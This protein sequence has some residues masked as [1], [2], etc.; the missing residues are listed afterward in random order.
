MNRLFYLI[1]SIILISETLYALPNP[2]TKQVII[3]DTINREK[4]KY[5]PGAIIVKFKENS[6]FL[7]ADKKAKI[8]LMK[9]SFESSVV[10]VETPFKSMIKPNDDSYGISRITEIRFTSAVDAY[11]LAQEISKNPDVEYAEP[12]YER[13]LC[14]L[15][16][17]DARYSLQW[18]PKMIGLERAWEVTQGSPE[19][20]IAIVDG[21]VFMNHE[22]LKDNIWKNPNEIAGNGIDDD[23]NGYVDDVNGWDFVGNYTGGGFSPDNDPQPTS[24]QV[25]HGTHVA[26]CAAAVGNNGIGVAGSAWKCKILPIKVGSDN[27]NVQGIYNGY[28]AIYY[29]ALMGA[30]IINCSWG[31][32]GYSKSEQ[33]LINKATEMGSV[34]IA[35]A[36]NEGNNMANYGQYPAQLD[37]VISIGSSDQSDNVSGFSNYGW[38]NCV[39][40]PGSG[41]QST[42]PGNSYTNMDGTSMASPVLA[43]VAAL[44]KSVHPTWKFKEI[45]HQLRSTSDDVF[46]GGNNKERLLK[47]GRVNAFKAVSYNSEFSTNTIPGISLF[48][49]SIGDNNEINK[50]GTFKSNFEFKNYLAK[51]DL[52]SITLEPMDDFITLGKNNTLTVTNFDS[53]QNHTL[54]LDVTLQQSNPWFEG[55][56]TILV[57]YKSTNYVDYQVIEIPIKIKSPNK[58]TN[59]Y[60]FPSNLYANWYGAHSPTKDVFWAVGWTAWYQRGM[61]YARGSANVFNITSLNEELTTVYANDFFN[62]FIGS[63]QRTVTPNVSQILKTTDAGNSFTRIDVTTITPFINDIHFFNSKYALLL[64]D[65]ISNKFGIGYTADEGVSWKKIPQQPTAQAGENGFVG[66]VSF[67]NDNVW[68]GTNRGRILYSIDKGQ[69]WAYSTV[70]AGKLI[71]KIA[72]GNANKGLAL[73]GPEKDP[74]LLAATNDGGKTWQKSVMDFASLRQLPIDLFSAEDTE[75]IFVVTKEGRIYRTA[76]LGK[77]WTSILTSM[78]QPIE[79][80]TVKC[81][82]ESGRLWMV[83]DYVSYTDFIYG[84]PNPQLTLE[85]ENNIIFKKTEVGKVSLANVKVRNTGNTIIE[86]NSVTLENSPDNEFSELVGDTTDLDLNQ[87]ATFKLKFSPINAGTKTGTFIIKTNAQNYTIPLSGEAYDAGSVKELESAGFQFVSLSPNPADG[88]INLNYNAD[89]AVNLNVGLYDI[90]GALVRNV[91]TGF[92][93][94]GSGNININTADLAVGTYYL[95]ISI[96][97]KSAV[98]KFVVKR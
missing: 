66:S 74:T 8:E 57:S 78:A 87:T 25:N 81:L 72:F 68:F 94:L 37:N 42:V 22:D 20:L 13:K 63:V 80:A 45:Y 76:D 53:T 51:S 89:N 75:D 27:P 46:S 14:E 97:D 56:A 96:D 48:Q 84:A 47:Y 9:S 4:P 38:T 55:T 59:A 73:Y 90:S 41:I 34:V 49:Y 54:E 79:I 31:G 2:L 17:N 6:Q 33:D 95:N 36:G 83:N 28:Q 65:Q 29:A 85:S 23:G 82:E 62:A 7:K 58:S 40:A 50:F 30:D 60:Y 24:N 93:A 64:G 12:M 52:I 69:A 43:G 21:G 71:H 67:Y 10:S 39:Y 88:Q 1:I 77:T 19:V 61:Y 11:T 91:Y 16:P 70:E 32:G 26:G 18:A 35:A 5:L 3:N 98:M 92:T 15:V 44:V 86:F